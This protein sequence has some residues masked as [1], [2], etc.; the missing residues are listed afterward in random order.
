MEERQRA[1]AAP[2]LDALRRQ[3]VMSGLREHDGRREQH[4]PIDEPRVRRRRED[5]ERAAKAR[6]DQRRGRAAGELGAEL[7]QHSRER[8]RGKIRLVEVGDAQLDVVLPEPLGEI[9]HFRRFRRR[10][11]AVQ[12]EDPHSS[13]WQPGRQRHLMSPSPSV[14]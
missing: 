8:Q 2:F 1:A 4:Q 6:S 3:Q 5:R 10:G 7:L 12:V 13:V 9:R 11:E 14:L